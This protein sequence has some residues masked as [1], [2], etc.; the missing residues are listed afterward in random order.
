MNGKN[1][2]SKCDREILQNNFVLHDK[3]ID[4]IE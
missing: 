2:C 3:Q 1:G 4:V